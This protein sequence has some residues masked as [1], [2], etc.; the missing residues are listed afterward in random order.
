MW[1][2]RLALPLPRTHREAV[3]YVH[4]LE[5][6]DVTTLPSGCLEAAI[7]T[8]N[9]PYALRS[10]ILQYDIPGLARIAGGTFRLT[11]VATYKGISEL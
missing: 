7:S 4:V 2:T 8:E 11:S 5:W 3:T 10:L 6:N 9:P 1:S